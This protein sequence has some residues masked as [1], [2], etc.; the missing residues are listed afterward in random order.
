MA[1]HSA[2]FTLKSSCPI[3]GPFTCS[4]WNRRMAEGAERVPTVRLQ[5]G[6][7]WEHPV[8]SAG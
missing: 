4:P 8:F 5:D 1:L 3:L 7:E 2:A 6:G